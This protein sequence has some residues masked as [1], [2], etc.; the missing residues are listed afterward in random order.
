MNAQ[1]D[2]VHAPSGTRLNL[3]IHNVCEYYDQL[4]IC[5]GDSSQGTHPSMGLIDCGTTYIHEDSLSV[6]TKVK[7]LAMGDESPQSFEQ[8]LFC[9]GDDN[10][11]LSYRIGYSGGS[12]CNS[13]VIVPADTLLSDSIAGCK[14]FYSTIAAIR[15]SSTTNNFILYDTTLSSPVYAILLNMTPVMIAGYSYNV[16]AAVIGVNQTNQTVLNVINMQTQTIVK[17]TVLGPLF[18]KPLSM[19]FSTN[20]VVFLAAEPG[21]SIVSVLKYNPQTGIDT[22]AV[23]YPASGAHVVAWVNGILHFQPEQ[24]A[25]SNGYDKQV[26]LFDAYNM[27]PLNNYNINKRLSKLVHSANSNVGYY[28]YMTLVE[29]SALSKVFLYSTNNYSIIDSVTTAMNPEFFRSDFRCPVSIDE[30]D[31]SW[32]E[33]KVFPNPTA[34]NINIMAAGLIC[35]RDYKI[36]IVDSNGKVKYESIVHAKMTLTLPIEKFPAGTYFVRIH[37]LKGFVT[38]KIIIE[39]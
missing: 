36:D 19:D 15:S 11:L 21:D 18:T 32:V 34:N 25:S 37:S 17:D 6:F 26:F 7:Y 9:V 30:Y 28:P 5:N 31:D 35:G 20:Q 1:S 38:K 24:D 23:V 10:R 3:F 13:T 12:P 14:I 2:V 22:A 33:W 29:D 8:K 39:H 16:Y 4:V 27:Q